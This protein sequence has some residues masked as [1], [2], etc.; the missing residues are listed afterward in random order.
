[1]ISV[2]VDQIALSAR[3][4]QNTARELNI[5]TVDPSEL[6]SKLYQQPKGANGMKKIFTICMTFVIFGALTLRSQTVSTLAGPGI[7]VDDALILN[8]Q[9]GLFGSNYAGSA[10]FRVTLDGNV[11]IYADGFNT[12][13]G[14]ALGDDGNLFMVDNLGG[15]V[16]KIL[17][18]GS[19][20]PYGPPIP[21]PSGVIKDPFSDT[22]WVTSYTN[23]QILKLAPDS[24]ITPFISGGGLNGPVGF[25]EDDSNNIYIGNFDDGEIYR[26]TPGGGLEFLADVPGQPLGF[27]TYTSGY[28]YGTALG[29]HRIYRISLTGEVE[30][31]AG[32]GIAGTVDGPASTARFNG[33]NGIIANAAG[34]TL[35][36]SDF[37]SQ[38]VR[39]ITDFVTDIED[40][41][42]IPVEI[43]LEQN[44]P[45]P[46]NP[47]TTIRYGLPSASEVTLKIFNMLG[48]EVATLVSQHKPAG[49]HSA[50]WNGT[51]HL[52][53][54]VA[55]GIYF[56]R[57]QIGT[58]VTTKK[59]I[60][61]K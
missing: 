28:I 29:G 34:D 39:I 16:F 56:Y 32:S 11:S 61:A 26:I 54:Q 2:F 52:G 36:I 58:H 31:F 15:R 40:A 9:G 41:V 48:H 13:N 59:M 24:S 53:K 35:F 33:P 14:L 7:N 51:N 12:P 27:I 18:D 5:V 55:S 8:P 44:Y 43:T 19:S 3:N 60:F 22:L 17:P 1:M 21:G 57:L 20:T 37:T 38:T 47:S 25:A 46:F 10:V 49:T 30:I 45:N 42:S 4:L 6:Q 50:T 23:D